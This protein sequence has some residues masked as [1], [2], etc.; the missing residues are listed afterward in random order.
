MIANSKITGTADVSDGENTTI[1]TGPGEQTNA[2]YY[3]CNSKIGGWEGFSA[4]MDFL[5][6]DPCPPPV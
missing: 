4:L 5:R 1:T 3:V 2:M 6:R